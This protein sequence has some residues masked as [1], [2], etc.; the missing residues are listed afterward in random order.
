MIKESLNIATLQLLYGSK[1]NQK[2]YF[3]CSNINQY[4]QEG[5]DI[6]Y[7]TSKE[8]SQNNSENTIPSAIGV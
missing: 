5:Q 2:D 4:Y 7:V 8:G 1:L 3:K 6:P